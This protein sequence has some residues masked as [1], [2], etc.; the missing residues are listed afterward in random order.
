MERA[1]CD[2][3]VCLTVFV[4]ERMLSLCGVLVYFHRGLLCKTIYDKRGV[5]FARSRIVIGVRA[6]SG[7]I[8]FR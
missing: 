5:L 6:L 4:F 2:L 1:P 7:L 8:Y 3:Y